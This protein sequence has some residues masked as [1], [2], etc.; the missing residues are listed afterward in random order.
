MCV[1][2]RRPGRVEARC[3]RVLQEKADGD[4]QVWAFACYHAADVHKRALLAHVI[5]NSRGSFR[6]LLEI[7][8]ADCFEKAAIAVTHK[9]TSVLRG[10]LSHSTCDTTAAGPPPPPGMSPRGE[11][12]LCLNP[13]FCALS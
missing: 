6:I 10:C 11:G 13:L 7:F 1:F 5:G 12:D 9:P 2:R 8:G 4:L 3:V